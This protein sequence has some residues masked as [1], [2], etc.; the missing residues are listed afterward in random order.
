MP[1]TPLLSEAPSRNEQTEPFA[2]LNVNSHGNVSSFSPELLGLKNEA[3]G[4]YLL[5]NIN[6]QS[7]AEIYDTCMAS[8]LNRDIQAGNEACRA[9]C[10]YFSVCGGGAPVNKLAETGSFAGDRTR[11]CE[12]TQMV[13]ID[14]ILDALERLDPIVQPQHDL[15]SPTN[16][17]AQC[18]DATA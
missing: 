1:G 2:M 12:L 6:T 10:E 18:H 7:L 3:Y 14:L 5:G 17:R 8:A 15:A 16:W 4:D 9:E 11:F 13:P